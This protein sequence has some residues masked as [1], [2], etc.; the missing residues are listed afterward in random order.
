MHT[1]LTAPDVIFDSKTQAWLERRSTIRVAF[2]GGARPPMHIGFDPNSFEGV[3]A[4]VLGLL[5]NTMGVRMQMLRFEDRP[6]ALQAMARGEVDMLALNDLTDSDNPVFKA[7]RP[8]LLN[9][10][11]IVRRINDPIKTDAGN[12]TERM[13]YIGATDS[14]IKRIQDQHPKSKLIPYIN[15]LNAL[16]ALAYDQVDAV[17]TNAVT[18]EF[19]LSSFY[20]N[21]LFITADPNAGSVADI[22]F[23]VNA[24]SPLLLEAVNQSL[25]AIP[26]A[27]ML[28]IT[29][30][31]ALSNNFVIAP[32][33]LDLSPEQAAWIAEHPKLKVVVADAY[34]PL[35]FFDEKNRLNGLSA[36]MLRLVERLTGLEF[37]VVRSDSVSD[38]VKRLQDGKVDL[39]AALSIGDFRL[40]PNQYTRPYMISPFVVVTRRNEAGIKSLEELNGLR[41]ALPWGSPVSFT[42]QNQF[43]NITQVTAQNATQG[44]EMLAAGEVEG[45]VHTQYGA[46]YFINH[47]FQADLHI[48]SVIG[49]HPARVAM[50]VGP[51]HQ[52]LKEIIN[53]A[54]LEIRPDEFKAMTDRWRVHEPPAV[55]SSWS[56]YKDLVWTVVVAA[57]LFG[58]I[59]IVW[60]YYLRVQINKRKKAEQALEDQLQFT[61]T[62]IDGAPLALYV[63]DGGGRLADC[64]RAYLDFFN[65]KREDVI[66]KTLME[67]DVAGVEVSAR[68]HQIY[69]DALEH[70]EATFDDMDFELRG[71][72]YRV[73]HWILPY[74]NSTG[75][76]IGVIGGWLDITERSQLIEQLRQ[77][78]EDA[79][80]ANRSKSVFLASMS[81]EI[82]TPISALIGLIELL[83]VRSGT[84]AEIDES[85]EVAHQSAQSLLSLIGDIL[86]LSKIE[87]GAMTPSSRPTQLIELTQSIHRLFLTN[88][89]KKNIEF[90]LVTEVQHNGVMIDAL[91]L[92]QVISNLV[93]NAIK[94][95]EQGSVQL[96]LRELPDTQIEGYARFAIQVTDTGKGLNEAQRKEVFEP[97]VQADPQAHRAAG[98]GLG[99][100]I[101]ASLATLLGAKLSVDSQPGLGSC[102]TLLFEA[103]LV[104]I[105]QDEDAPNASLQSTQKLRIL[106]VEDHAP[107]RTLLCRQLEFLG[108]E[109]VPCDDGEAALELWKSAESEFDLTIT[110]CNM[111]KLNGYDLTRRMREIEQQKALR[112]HS[113]F[114]LTANAQSEA[115]EMCLAAGMS[116]CLFKPVSIEGLASAINDVAQSHARRLKAASVTKGGELEK[117]RLL[118]PES[119]AP[120]VEQILISLREDRSNLERLAQECDRPGLG[121]IA[122]KIRGGATLTGDSALAEACSALERIVSE[123]IDASY[124]FEVEKVKSCLY[125]F[126]VELRGVSS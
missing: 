94:F 34:A 28:R 11:V 67:S 87:A 48:A 78:K 118:S 77:A 76:Y 91:M 39:I 102:F 14:H 12:P 53:A 123:N 60:N 19:L 122:H 26:V 17:R 32:K 81:H 105:T 51:G 16:A 58:L 79:N 27:D 10:K 49:T 42:V 5:Q 36:D 88:A 63:R 85:L 33:S 124:E 52:V 90:R 47:H 100:S 106:V 113:I 72:Q 35:T 84:A 43:P 64:N 74:L 31:W 120:L 54:L 41:L 40:E 125:A 13:A 97:F 89:R 69:M 1:P 20:R 116:R 55:A 126:E 115:S 110:D 65:I 21:D 46:D 4:D 23:A 71:Q 59:F 44:L 8:Y 117:I 83:R 92:N 109:A 86:D 56:T 95:T 96:L 45:S 68:Y 57:I 22:N 30:N 82:R 9:H 61:R 93:S 121:R 112:P 3:T 107:N 38:M 70:G 15:H 103:E 80:D 7:S 29:S 99:L 101:C 98:T 37:E 6:H 25:A 73:Y 50:A 114:G 75:Q 108:H 62:L 66:G 2:W 24:K 18:A 119:Y 104:E 111:P